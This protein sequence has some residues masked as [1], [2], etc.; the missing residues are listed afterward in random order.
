[1]DRIIDDVFIDFIGAAFDGL[2]DAAAAADRG[3][4]L[5]VDA[6]FL[7]GILDN[8]L[9]E[10]DFF[11]DVGVLPQFFV[12]MVKA[13]F[14]NHFLVFENADFRGSAPRIDRQYFVHCISPCLYKY[15]TRMAP[16]L[17]H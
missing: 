6:G 2:D 16:L 11:I 7:D 17:R 10:F 9:S 1:M 14:L 8:L 5:P 15:N 3:Y 4:R 12:G 13:E